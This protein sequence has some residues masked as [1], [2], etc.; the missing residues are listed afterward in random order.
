MLNYYG[1]YKEL[2]DELKKYDLNEKDIIESIQ[3]VNLPIRSF[4]RPFMPG[5]SCQI[6]LK[7][8]ISQ[9]DKKIV[10]DI[11]LSYSKREISSIIDDMPIIKW[12][13]KKHKEA[14][15]NVAIIWRDHFL[16]ENIGLLNGF[17]EMGV[18]PENILALD[19]GDSTKHRYE[20]W[21]TFEKL[22]FKVDILD[23]NSLNNEEEMIRS[24]NLISDFINNRKD[25]KIIILD[26]GAIVTKILND[27]NCDN[28]VGILELTEMGLRRINNS[29]SNLKYPVM[30]LAKTS[31][32]RNIT[33]PEISNSIFLKIL[34]LLGAEKIVGRS[35]IVCGYGDLGSYLAER[36][37]RYGVRTVVCDS[38]VMKVIIASENGF[39]TYKDIEKAVINEEPILIVGSSGYKSITRNVIERINSGTYITAGATADLQVFLDMEIEGLLKKEIV[40]NIGTHYLYKNKKIVVLGNGR[41]VNLFDSEAI[42]N[43]SNDI[44]KSS[45]LVVANELINGK[46]LLE[47]KVYLD[48]VEEY[49]KQSGILDKYYN[50]YLK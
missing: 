20:I 30:N 40:T 46:R 43:K 41:S 14:L 5:D 3:K 27:I 37:R 2:L 48:K 44:F 29:D 34:E 9:K 45:M 8:G 26:D 23:N 18:E 42:P 50:D 17:L 25:K 49:I 4:S 36:F 12:Y 10:E 21:K 1:T 19:K 47:C 28:V 39:K 16:E 22:G 24:I 6:L 7:D 35:V 31:L 13:S 15:K 38:D 32:K 11:C 33:Y